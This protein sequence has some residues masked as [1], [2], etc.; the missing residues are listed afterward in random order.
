MIQNRDV[1][2][3]F[4]T[5]IDEVYDA[6]TR[7]VWTG[8][9]PPL[10]LFEGLFKKTANIKVDVIADDITPFDP[11]KP[12]EV[13]QMIDRT[14]HH[15]VVTTSANFQDKLQLNE[16]KYSSAG[17]SSGAGKEAYSASS[18]NTPASDS[19]SIYG[20]DS[21]AI[22]KGESASYTDLNLAL[23]RAASRLVEMSGVSYQGGRR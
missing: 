10:E 2:R 1:A 22:S 8:E 15:G 17:D 18:D 6:G 21:I 20:A 4:V 5:L 14:V 9:G 11:M 12:G 13:V 7:I 19:D 3:R 23:Q 16:A